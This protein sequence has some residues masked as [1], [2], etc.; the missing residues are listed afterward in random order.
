[1][2]EVSSLALT[3]EKKADLIEEYG[4]RLA[5]AQVMI[6][7]RFGNLPT[8]VVNTLRNQLRG[9]HAEV[10]VVKNTLMGRALEEAGLPVEPSLMA[11]PYMVTFVY[12]D[13]ASVAKTLSDFARLNPAFEI[14]GGLVGGK[15]ADAAQVQSLSTLPSREQILAQVLG[16]LQAP[17]R[18]LVNVLA[19]TIRGLVTVLNERAK[20]L[21]GAN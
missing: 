8:P 15:Y 14:A 7:S 9:L 17:M 12:D 13:I 19:G 10:M 3:R 11:G 16:G 4:R 2:K 20:Q 21:E 18:G 6:W 5:R 1:M